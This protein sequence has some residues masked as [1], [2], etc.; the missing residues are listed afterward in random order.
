[1]LTFKIPGISVRNSY[2][3]VLSDLYPFLLLLF[4]LALLTSFPDFDPVLWLPAILA[5]PATT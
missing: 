2:I 5:V 1:M 3:E 4:L